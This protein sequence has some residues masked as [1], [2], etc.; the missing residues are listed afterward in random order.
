VPV[1][2]LIVRPSLNPTIDFVV[3]VVLALLVVPLP[4]GLLSRHGARHDIG[5]LV[6]P[7][8]VVPVVVVPVPDPP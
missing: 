6:K 5:E 4:A 3:P 1:P 8:Q 2:F 7:V